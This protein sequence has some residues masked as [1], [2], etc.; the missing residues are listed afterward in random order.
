MGE[1][2]IEIARRNMPEGFEFTNVETGAEPEQIALVKGA[3]YVI[4]GSMNTVRAPVIEAM[5]KARL[6]QK[7]GIGYDRI[8]LPTAKRM[9]IGVAITAGINKMTVSEFTIALILSV[10]KWIPQTMQAMITEGRWRDANLR[11]RQHMIQGKTIG[12]VGFGNIGQ[13]VAQ[14]LQGF[15]T[16]EIL[17]Y[18]VFRQS[19]E[20]E[21]QLGVRFVAELDQMIPQCDI[22]SLHVPH[23][24]ETEGMFTRERIALMKPSAILINTCR[25]AV[26]DEPALVEA[27]K[28]NRIAGAG[29]DVFV[30]EPV[31]K[32]NPLFALPS[33]VVTPHIA[34]SAEE[35]REP[36]IQHMLRNIALAASGQE[37]PKADVVLPIMRP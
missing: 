12:L 32:D 31:S 15:E 5:D 19:P 9:G 14:R 23:I 35:L 25:G 11:A 8:H 24:P 37:L 2:E 6:I 16:K 18:D 7:S 1:E 27:L 28:A 20:R 13:S 4:G 33:V 17:Y 30:K 29:L 22:V 36:T 26:I 21:A 3:D 34:G 10:Y